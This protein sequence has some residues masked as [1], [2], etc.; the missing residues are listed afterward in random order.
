MVLSAELSSTWCKKEEGNPQLGTGMGAS[1]S[2]TL[3]SQ[4]IRAG[5][6]SSSVPARCV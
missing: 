6:H 5:A 2:C 3:L 4:L 1:P